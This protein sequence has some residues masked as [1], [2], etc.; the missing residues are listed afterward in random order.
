M[1]GAPPPSGLLPH[2]DTT[3]PPHQ[4]LSVLSPNPPTHIHPC[5]GGS[6]PPPRAAVPLSGWPK[7]HAIFLCFP[8]PPSSPSGAPSPGRLAAACSI[9]MGPT[10]PD[11]VRPWRSRRPAA[12]LLLMATAAA[13]AA[14]T[15]PAVASAAAAATA[16]GGGGGSGGGGGGPSAAAAAAAGGAPP[17]PRAP[18]SDMDDPTDAWAEWGETPESR[19]S[20]VRRRRERPIEAGMNVDA[21]LGMAGKTTKLFFTTLRPGVAANDKDALALGARYRNMLAAGGVTATFFADGKGGLI[22]QAGSFRDAVNAK[23]FLI[24]QPEAKSGGEEGAASAANA[25]GGEGWGSA[26]ATA[27]EAGLT[28]ESSAAGEPHV[29]GGAAKEEL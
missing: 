16:D 22:C 3:S 27:A 10:L 4:P 5:L 9:A 11:G 6:P 8:A 26:Q 12:A 24:R 23:D 21:L 20:G 7:H 18:P 19:R 2:V 15:V 25:S 17:P 14:V 28:V 29:G 1:H 13:A